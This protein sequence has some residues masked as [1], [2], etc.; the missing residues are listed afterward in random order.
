MLR[1]A[2]LARAVVGV[3]LAS[4]LCFAGLTPRVYPCV[5]VPPVGVRR[6]FLDSE[7]GNLSA[8]LK[9][10][11]GSSPSSAFLSWA[12]RPSGAVPSRR[13]SFFCFIGIKPVRS[14]RGPLFALSARA[15][16]VLLRWVARIVLSFLASLLVCGV[17]A[18]VT[19][20]FVPW[21]SP[22]LT[23]RGQGQQ[24][25]FLPC[26]WNYPGSLGALTGWLFTR[27]YSHPGFSPSFSVSL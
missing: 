12:F 10:G 18:W 2:L 3:S 11:F 14:A 13:L 5:S 7:L 17:S 16:C 26:W 19:P 23:S 20:G 9:F 21:R 22:C 4:V 15:K 8:A 25:G 6:V 27:A 24:S 1:S